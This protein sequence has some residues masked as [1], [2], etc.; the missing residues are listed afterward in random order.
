MRRAK[1]QVTLWKSRLDREV[2]LC[3]VYQDIEIDPYV[4]LLLL[5]S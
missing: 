3:Y 4:S 5:K 1:L 2:N